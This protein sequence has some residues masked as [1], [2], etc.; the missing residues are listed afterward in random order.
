MRIGGVLCPWGASVICA[1]M[2][3]AEGGVGG[4]EGMTVQRKPSDD[5]GSGSRPVE[6]IEMQARRAFSQELFAL[7][8]RIL[9]TPLG[10]SVIVVAVLLQR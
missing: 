8:G 9:D 10:N 4:I 2:T 1:I 6:R 5:L 7:L 3:A